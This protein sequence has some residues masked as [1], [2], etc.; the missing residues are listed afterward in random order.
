[1]GVRNTDREQTWFAWG[2]LAVLCG[3][4]AILFYSPDRFPWSTRVAASG[5]FVAFAGVLAMSRQVLRIGPFSWIAH[6]V[7]YADVDPSTLTDAVSKKL[8]DSD[9]R[10]RDAF[11]QSIIGPY[12]VGIG[13]ILN[14]FSGYF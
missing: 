10:Q 8:A 3:I 6:Q 1:M 4:A 2:F 12:L 7:W 5:G 9:E 13:T 14:G 11:F